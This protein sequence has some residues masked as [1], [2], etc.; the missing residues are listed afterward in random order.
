MII[1]ITILW[2][3]YICIEGYREAWYFYNQVNNKNGIKKELHPIFTIQRITVF[4]LLLL[5]IKSILWYKLLMITIA[6]TILS[7][8]FH[9]G[10]YYYFRN[11][12]DNAYPKGWLSQS[13]TS[14]AITTKYLT[15]TIR[16]VG[17][18]VGLSL[19]IFSLF[20]L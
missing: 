6:L 1:L 2:I 11:K 7:P 12:I 9:D 20:S 8:F 4:T 10:S 5:I 16:I 15:P 14:T 13:T 19:I 3:V 17:F 18:V